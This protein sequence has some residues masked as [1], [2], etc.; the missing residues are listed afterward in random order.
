MILENYKKTIIINAGHHN[1]DPGKVVGEHNERDE[2]KII[3]DKVV[4][5]LHKRTDF[6]VFHVPDNLDLN[7]SIQWAN[8]RVHHREDGFLIDIHLNASSYKSARG[9]E[10]FYAAGRSNNNGEEIA[11]AMSRNISETLEIPDRG[12]KPD[13]DAYVGSLGWLRQTKGE[14]TLVE[15]CFMTNAQDW[16]AL[17]MDGGHDLAAL[18]IAKGICELYGVELKPEEVEEKETKNGFLAFLTLLASFLNIWA[19]RSVEEIEATKAAYEDEILSKKNVI[20]IGVGKKDQ[21]GDDAVVVLVEKKVPLDKLKEEDVVPSELDG[22]PTDVVEIGEQEP[23]AGVHSDRERPVHGGI[24]AI[25]QKG[26]ACTLG[27]IVYKDGEPYALMNT[28]CANPHWKGAK[29]GDRIIQPSGNDGGR[30]TGT[31][32]VIGHSTDYEELILDGQ[33]INYFDSA[34]VKLDIDATPL[35]LEGIGDIEPEIA[36]VKPGDQVWKSGRT[37]GVQ[38]SNV[39][40][41]NVT[42]YCNYGDEYGKGKFVNQIVV[43]NSDKYFTAGGDSSSLVIDSE[44]RPVGQIFAGSSRTATL[45]PIKPIMERFQVTFDPNEEPIQENVGYMALAL[46]GEELYMMPIPETIQPGMVVETQYAMNF[47]DSA[48]VS[49][50]K[51]RVLPRGT[52]VEVLESITT[53]QG[54]VWAKVRVK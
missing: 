10:A 50:N 49:N 51:K 41:T 40:A 15:V 2:V 35:F 30:K 39:I 17:K 38:T 1:T 20:G 54:Y 5:I 52:Q 32:D 8:K 45:S 11:E 23:M 7:E 43:E 9:S 4:T 22:I 18:G 34:I 47:R 48:E 36:T 24:S 33:T 21:V 6:E 25:W 27:A 28:H 3:R 14:A 16:A 13:T 42:M 44:R 19:G 37:T 12:A 53:N 31:K 29:L 46:Q 26:T